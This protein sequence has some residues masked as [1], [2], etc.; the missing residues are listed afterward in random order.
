[1]PSSAIN[2]SLLLFLVVVVVLAAA[3]MAAVVVVV[4]VVMVVVASHKLAQSGLVMF[5]PMVS[6]AFFVKYFSSL[7]RMCFP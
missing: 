5:G 3:T 2:N 1:M 6:G 7:A 4:E